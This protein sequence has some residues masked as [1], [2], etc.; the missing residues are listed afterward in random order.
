MMWQAPAMAL[1]AQAFLLTIAL[2]HDTSAL[3]RGMAA[4]LGVVVTAMSIQLML[5]HRLIMTTDQVL[6]LALEYRMGLV[7]SAVDRETQVETIKQDR[8][9]VDLIKRVPKKEGF[10]GWKSVNVWVGGLGVFT[11]VNVLI[12]VLAIMDMAGVQCV[13]HVGDANG[14]PRCLLDL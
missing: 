13:L 4:L 9:G 14:A 5:K 7:S 2:G 1:T 11:V 6:M 10:V 3:A 8:S 12:L